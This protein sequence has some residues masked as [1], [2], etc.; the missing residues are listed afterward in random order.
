V[1]IL[2]GL[3]AN[4]KVYDRTA[5]ATLSSNNV[6][7]SGVL[8]GDTVSLNTNGYL[9]SFP[10]AGVGSSLAVSVSGLTLSGAAAANYLL[11][12]PAS[13]LAGIT[14][15][16]VSILSGL[17]ANNKVYDRTATATLSS[18]N[19]VLSGVLSGDTVS[20]NTNGYLASFPGAGVGSSLAVSV[21]GLTLSG[22]AAAN[23]L[24]AQPAGLTASITAPSVQIFASLPNIIISWTANATDFVL[25]QTASLT[26]PVTWSTVTS[27][28]TISGT[29]N[30]V[31]ISASS[32]V[33]YFELIGAP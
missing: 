17:T 8:S 25:M 12:Q 21:S 14:P 1:S 19:V 32:A 7:L 30:S 6:V 22:A 27:Q 11:A 20:L 29:N 28:I 9:A 4:N 15:A 3:T 31:T 18:N 24:L 10:G 33:Q 2:S 26:P 16:P 13:L 5:T 23:Y